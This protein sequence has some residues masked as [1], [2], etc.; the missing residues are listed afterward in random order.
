[1]SEI[2]TVGA[3]LVPSSNTNS[4]AVAIGGTDMPSLIR[5]S[6]MLA[7]SDLVPAAYRG[8]PANVLLAALAGSGFGFDVTMS[9]RS[10]NVIQ[11][12]PTLKP[13]VMLGLVR[14]AGH[15]VTGTTSADGATVTGRRADTGDEMT[16]SFTR[17]D[18]QRAGL[19]GKGAWKTYPDA[20]M[21]A[22]VVSKLCRML[23]QDVTLG[24]AYVAEELGGDSYDTP[25]APAGLNPSDVKHRVVEAAG[26]DVDIAREIWKAHGSPTLSV[27]PEE[28]E[29]MIAAARQASQA[30][31]I[32]AEVVETDA[33]STDEVSE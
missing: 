31:V 2:K 11:G 26:G 22:R 15:S 19:L 7:Q 6:E 9:M 20:M 18:A 27:S 30:D 3:D 4:T 33:E 28:A 8:K 32:D 13:E 23:F 29:V 1:M 17:E 25:A 5:M 12:Q 10:F 14:K 21:W 16:V 24:C